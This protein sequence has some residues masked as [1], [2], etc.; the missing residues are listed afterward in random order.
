MNNKYVTHSR[1]H[2]GEKES[3]RLGRNGMAQIGL[4]AALGTVLGLLGRLRG[5]TH[6]TTKGGR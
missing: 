3:S 2:R 5:R 1:T 4:E 6:V